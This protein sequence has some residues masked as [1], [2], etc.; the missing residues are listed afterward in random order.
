MPLKV[1]VD[2]DLAGPGLVGQLEVSL[3]QAQQHMCRVVFIATSAPDFPFVDS[4]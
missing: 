3:E 4:R 2:A 1:A